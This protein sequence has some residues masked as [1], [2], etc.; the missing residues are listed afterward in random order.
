MKVQDF[1]QKMMLDMYVAVKNEQATL[2]E[3]SAWP[4]V[5]IY[6]QSLTEKLSH[7]EYLANMLRIIG[8]LLCSQ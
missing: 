7:C 5:L 1:C 3:R 2:D 8:E 4:L 6:N